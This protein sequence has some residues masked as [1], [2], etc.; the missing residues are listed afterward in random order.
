MEPIAKELGIEVLEVRVTGEGGAPCLRVSVDKEG[1]VMLRD[2]EQLSREVRVLLEVEF[3]EMR[4]MGFEV[5]SPGP[6]RPLV[7]KEHFEKYCG[8]CVKIKTIRDYEGRKNFRGFLKSVQETGDIEVLVDQQTFRI[9]LS[10]IER[11]FLA[12]G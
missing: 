7:K 6:E 2:C 9:Q 12:P 5:S 11:A 8:H 1:G 4:S 10:D 3:P